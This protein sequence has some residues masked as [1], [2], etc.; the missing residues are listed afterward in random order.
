[1]SLPAR[2]RSILARH[3]GA[4]KGWWACWVEE[5]SRPAQ[6]ASCCWQ[7]QRVP[8]PLCPEQGA[9]RRAQ[10]GFGVHGG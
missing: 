3:R 1:M 2:G 4:G 8:D 6:A 10:L 9:K 5:R 7:R